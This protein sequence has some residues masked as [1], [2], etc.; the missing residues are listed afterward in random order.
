MSSPLPARIR[1]STRA[2][3]SLLAERPFL[4]DIR[5]GVQALVVIV[6]Q[7]PRVFVDNSLDI[8]ELILHRKDLVHLLLILGENHLRASMIQGHRPSRP[9]PSPGRVAPEL[10]RNIA[11]QSFPSRAAADCRR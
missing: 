6:A 8:R 2:F 9:P 4:L 3:D 1:A 5:M 7:A 11:P 10:H